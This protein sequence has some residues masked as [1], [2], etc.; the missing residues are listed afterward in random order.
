[1][2]RWL[3]WWFLSGIYVF[4]ARGYVRGTLACI[5]AAGERLYG[6]PD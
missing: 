1:M 5:L 6:Y 2:L 4:T 3:H